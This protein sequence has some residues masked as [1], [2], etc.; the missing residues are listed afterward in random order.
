MRRLLTAIL[1]VLLALPPAFG[2]EHPGTT[3]DT[4]TPGSTSLPPVTLE[5]PVEQ[6]A[7]WIPGARSRADIGTLPSGPDAV[8]GRLLLDEAG[9]RYTEQIEYRLSELLAIPYIRLIS[10]SVEQSA[11]G[12]DLLFVTEAGE[13]S[14][15]GRMHAFVLLPA[16][17][18]AAGAFAADARSIIEARIAT[19]LARVERGT[20]REETIAVSAGERPLAIVF[21]EPGTWIPARRDLFSESLRA[22]TVVGA[23]PFYIC[24]YG[25]CPVPAPETTA[26]MVVAGMV[27]GAIVG[28]SREIAAG[29]WQEPPQRPGFPSLE[30]QAASPAIVDAA[31]QVLS[32]AGMQ[33][34]LNNRLSTAGIDEKLPRWEMPGRVAVLKQAASMADDDHHYAVEAFPSE[35]VLVPAGAPGQAAENVPAQLVVKARLRFIDRKTHESRETGAE[36]QAGP[37]TLGE[38]AGND[39]FLLREALQEGCHALAGDLL[40]KAQSI[41]S[42]H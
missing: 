17:S 10:V 4:P 40:G 21:D 15:S 20:P 34:C 30:L 27:L 16:G 37:R 9:L 13:I 31:M 42:L 36:W 35:V 14:G 22:G 11:G 39:A 18:A 29:H 5:Q 38:W 8:R 1:A 24:L 41:W 7:V 26:V 3:A 32:P 2:S 19:R 23:A 12:P 25:G 33:A 28:I 6:T